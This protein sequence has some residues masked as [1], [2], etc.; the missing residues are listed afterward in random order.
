MS[1]LFGCDVSNYQTPS[2]QQGSFAV[3]QASAGSGWVNPAHAGHVAYARSVGRLVNHYHW[4]LPDQ[5]PIAEAKWFLSVANPI[6]GEGVS[7]DL[8]VLQG[9]AAQRSSYAAAWLSYVESQSG[10]SPFLYSYLSY[11]NSIDCTPLRRF[12][13]WM[14]YPNNTPGVNVPLAGWSAWTA[15]Q[16]AWSPIDR[17]VFNGDAAVWARLSVPRSTPA[18]PPV[19]KPVPP[20]APKPVPP[21]PVSKPAPPG[22]PP[23]PKPAPP[24]EDTMIPIPQSYWKGTLDVPAG[25]TK[26][27]PIGLTKRGGMVYSILAT[28][29]PTYAML[30]L[31]VTLTGPA[32]HVA[33]VHWEGWDPSTTKWTRVANYPYEDVVMTGS[34]VEHTYTM[35]ASAIPT[36]TNVA[37]EIVSPTADVKVSFVWA[38]GLKNT[39]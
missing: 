21:P 16:Y 33:R 18:P 26:S 36:A 32:G 1:A 9:T 22:L 24:K 4:A 35:I 39:V 27:L 38:S 29:A 3:I 13:L 12:P 10:A 15:H 30:T 5:D 8:E 28:K 14:A 23:A 7:L 31:S 34:P 6:P 11:L 25:S 37:A 17:D 19:P 2:Q 20:P